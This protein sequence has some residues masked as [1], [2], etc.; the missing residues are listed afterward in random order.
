MRWPG[1]SPIASVTGK[2][3]RL[4]DALPKE[5]QAVVRHAIDHP[6]DPQYGLGK[7]KGKRKS[8][9]SIDIFNQ[10]Y[11][12]VAEKTKDGFAWEFVGTHEAYNGYVARL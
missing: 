4:F 8:Y 12:A 10:D 2:F 7:L 5:V 3:Q 1:G 6:R 11:R 9:W